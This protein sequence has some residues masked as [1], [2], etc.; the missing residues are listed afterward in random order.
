[1]TLK[2]KA[3]KIKALVFDVDGVLTNG[4]IG[5]CGTEE[6]KFF[7]VRDGYGI[8]LAK[9][10]GLKVGALTGRSGKPNMIRAKELELDF[11]YEDCKDKRKAFETLLKEQCLNA[12]ECLYIGDDIVDIPILKRAGIGVIVFDAPDYMSEFCDFRTK[13]KGGK[14]AAREVID[15]ILKEQGKWTELLKKYIC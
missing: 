4:F 14:G 13:L 7:H 1:M 11:I 2:E 8:R 5:Y 10:A 12:D 6:V 9:R 3:S 15:W